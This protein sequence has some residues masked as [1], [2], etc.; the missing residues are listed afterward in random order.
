VRLVDLDHD[1]SDVIPTGSSVDSEFLFQRMEDTTL[2]ALRAGPGARLLD[3]AAGIGQDDRRLA[4]AG[5]WTVGAE[6]S[7]RM[8]ALAKMQDAEQ[9]VEHGRAVLRVRAWSEA[10]PFEGSVFDGAFCKGALDHFDDP[11]CCIQEMARVTCSSGRVVLAVA[12]FGSLGCRWARLRNRFTREAGFGGRRHY[13][14]PSDH[15][16][17][18]DTRLLR[19]HVERYVVIDEWTGVSLLWGVRAWTSLLERLPRAWAERLLRSADRIARCFPTLADVIVV[20]GP[21]QP[22][23]R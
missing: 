5:L 9:R 23:L 10:L 3:S 7:K 21:P 13:D 16:T 18:Y 14:V 8:M 6:P 22:A 20:A 11:L 19:A 4:R 15:F 12:N 1:M 17:R 2:E